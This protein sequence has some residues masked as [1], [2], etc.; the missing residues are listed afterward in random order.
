MRDESLFH[1]ALELPAGE[2]SAFLD[3]ECN[4]DA[5]LRQRLQVLLPPPAA[6]T[7]GIFRGEPVPAI[8]ATADQRP[9]NERPGS[10]IGNY[11]LLERIGEG[12]MGLVFVAEQQQPLRRRVALKV[13]KPGMDCS[14][15]IA[16][17]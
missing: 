11:L 2:R 8:Q 6:T 10:V 16:R 15:V 3:R 17:L 9:V 13:I 5:A 7:P 1:R 12:G 4:H 14:E